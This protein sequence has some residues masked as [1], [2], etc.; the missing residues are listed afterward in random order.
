MLYNFR[1]S[2]TFLIVSTLFVL[3]T[4]GYSQNT[5][6]DSCSQL[7]FHSGIEQEGFNL[8]CS[9]QKPDYLTM[10]VAVNP[11]SG[12][13]ELNAIRQLVKTEAV[14]LQTKMTGIKKPAAR[15]KYIFDHVQSTFLKQ[16]DLDADFSD[17]FE[18]G[19]HNCLTATLLYTLLL[20]ELAVKY[21]IKFMPGHVY[22]IA[23]A[24]DVPYIF[25]TTD[26][27]HGFVELNGTVQKN[28]IQSMRLM[29]FIASDNGK[30]KSTGD[31]FDRYYIKLNN[32]EMK[33]L[34]AY[35]YT[36]AAFATMLK[37]D[38][39]TAYDLIS[40]GILLAPMDE[41]YLM[42][43]EL[44]KQSIGQAN[45]TSSKRAR[46]LVTYYN[47]TKNENKKNQVADEFKQSVYLI[48][49]S[50]FPSPDSLQ[51]VYK[52]LYDGIKDEDMRKVLEDIY[53]TQF[54]A[55]LQTEDK[56]EEAFDFLYEAYTSGNKSTFIKNQMHNCINQLTGVIRFDNDGVEAYDSLAFKYPALSEFDLF[57]Y[58]RCQVIIS[59]ASSAFQDKNGEEGERLLKKFDDGSYYDKSKPAYCN[60]ASVYSL[61]GSYY[62]KKGNTARCK[63]SLKKGLTFDP[64]NWEI[65]EKL[66]E[67]N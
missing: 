34:V 48:L 11:K 55:Y 32:T 23:Y 44:L 4:N 42:Q 60:P 12:D 19:K 53:T 46:M 24:N 59:A 29:Q 10:A 8:L 52:T 14:F 15:L 66:R 49:F 5:R 43:E 36:N 16:Y 35:Q 50:S 57:A 9:G 21:T 41:M 37:Q 61:A 18:S 63:A 62:F 6:S 3:I 31:L 25:E 28:A 64:D 67:L 33:G 39:P 17:M 56:P 45:S 7:K 2:S 54:V 13:S 20:D 58:N 22:P 38:F 40:K 30:N 65:K 27:E 51:P 47:T 26:P 1:F